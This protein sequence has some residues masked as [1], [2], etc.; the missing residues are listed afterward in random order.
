V[1]VYLL[2]SFVA[3]C[4]GLCFACQVKILDQQSGVRASF[5]RVS[6]IG[7]GNKKWN[8]AFGASFGA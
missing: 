4:V 6:R 8:G 2:L 7:G 5:C 1:A 3:S